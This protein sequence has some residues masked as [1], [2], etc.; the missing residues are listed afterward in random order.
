MLDAPGRTPATAEDEADVGRSS[1]GG[2]RRWFTAGGYG[3]LR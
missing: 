3:G 2:A 1:A